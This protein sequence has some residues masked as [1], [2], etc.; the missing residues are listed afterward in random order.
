MVTKIKVKATIRIADVHNINEEFYVTSAQTAEDEIQKI[1]NEFNDIEIIRYGDNAHLRKIVSID[2][3]EY[4]Q[5]I[6]YFDKSLR[7]RSKQA[8]PLNSIH[9]FDKKNLISNR[10]T[11]D[12]YRCK[13][14][15]LEGKRFMTQTTVTCS[16]TLGKI[17][18]CSEYKVPNAK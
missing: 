5:P 14:C 10:D 4:A 11:S 17:L 12:T 18:Y 16:D 1:I 15:G 8:V 13:K 7:T 6:N 9:N 2:D 3:I